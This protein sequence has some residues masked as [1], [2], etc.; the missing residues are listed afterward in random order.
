MK[1][2][3]L[4]GLH[5]SNEAT[6]CTGNSKYQQGHK[7][8]GFRLDYKGYNLKASEVH[9]SMSGGR[10]IGQLAQIEV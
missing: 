3:E 8:Q 6:K 10:I 2:K 5:Q 1:D 9:R 7:L 4:R